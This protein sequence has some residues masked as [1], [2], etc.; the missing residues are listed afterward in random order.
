[1]I[2]YHKYSP[3]F[4]QVNINY[5]LTSEQ[6]KIAKKVS[7]N[8]L[9]DCNCLIYA[10]C[11]AG[12][13]EL[14]FDVIKTALLRGEQIGFTVPRREVAIEIYGRL[15]D[16]FPSVDIT[17]VHGGRTAKLV[18]QIIVLTT[19]QLYRYKKFFDL[20]I[21]DE[22]D[23]FPYSGDFVLEAMFYQS[24]RGNYVIMSATPSK[25]LLNKFAKEGE[26][27]TL[28]TRFHHHQMPVPKLAIK[29]LGLEYIC[30]Y[31]TLKRL[32]NSDKSVLVFAPTISEVETLFVFLKVL[33]KG[34]NS[35]IQKDKCECDY[36]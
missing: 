24:V 11:G 34:G 13:T 8:Y 33:L 30:L 21:F 31:L 12:K 16:A 22:I 4:V 19:H 27:L 36:L 18:S 28:F 5:A 2:V 26:V 6:D 25:K 10:V 15:V 1:M 35:F 23:A 29:F 20:L 9:K 17:L 14:I 7:E 32:I 3:A